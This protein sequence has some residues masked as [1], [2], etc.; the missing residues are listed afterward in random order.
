[1]DYIQ[2]TDHD[3][4]DMLKAI[5]VS[6]VDDLFKDIPS[7]IRLCRDLRL[8]PELPEHD[9]LKHLTLL[10]SH[11]A[12]L[13]RIPSFLGGGF[14]NHFIPACVEQLAA[15]GEFYT[16]YTPYQ[17]EASQ[18]TLQAIFEY[19]TMIC[20]LTGLDVSNASH[21]EGPTAL[22]EAIGMALNHSSRN[23][24]VLSEGLS[25]Q[26]REVVRTYFRH[27]GVESTSAP[28]VNG[29]TCL[30]TVTDAACIVIQNP[31]ALG[32]I[33]DLEQTASWAKDTGALSIA[34]VN[35]IS[36]GLLKSPGEAG[37]DIAVGD[38]QPLGIPMS[39][40]GPTFGFMAA[41][42][43]FLRRMPG[44][45]VGETVDGEGRRGFCLTLQAREQHIRREKASSNIC[46]NQALMALRGTLY[47]SWLGKN[48]IRDLAQQCVQR[49]HYLADRISAI[50]GIRPAFSA[51][52]FHEFTVLL[53]R[54]PSE[55]NRK[56]W[57]RR[58]QGGI[59]AGGWIPGLANAWLLCAT[60]KNS[61][62]EIENLAAATAEILR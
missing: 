62:Q 27:R 11:N 58:I 45:I 52:F 31:N 39:F 53:P 48:G 2:N 28:L 3:V 12:S 35:P 5:G 47:L 46:T 57:E 32:Y 1:M 6:S 41:R 55:V 33:E 4:A 37:F 44:R 15:R 43:E 13:D 18:G 21:Y 16:A 26:Y 42:Q 38:G 40:G 9:L 56:L 23:R 59:D 7:E 19:Q 17:P 36:L 54:S 22:A 49:A 30:D 60:E 29:T 25:P 8:P 50:P 10:E 51:P 34:V 24:I 14:Y 20:E 61:R